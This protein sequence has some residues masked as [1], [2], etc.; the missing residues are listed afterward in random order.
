MPKRQ[1]VENDIPTIL[2][3][4]QTPEIL[5]LIYSFVISQI[6][7][8]QFQQLCKSCKLLSNHLHSLLFLNIKTLENLQ[9]CTRMVPTLRMARL[10]STRW[11]ISLVNIREIGFLDENPGFSKIIFRWN[12]NSWECPLLEKLNILNSSITESAL[13]T[14]S[15]KFPKLKYLYV[16]ITRSKKSDFTI[17]DFP[18]LKEFC[19]N[20]DMHDENET[21]NTSLRLH[22]INLKSL[23]KLD[24]SGYIEFLD[25]RLVPNMHTIRSENE[26]N[27]HHIIFHD[28]VPMLENLTLGDGELL[29]VDPLSNISWSKIK[30]LTLSYS[31]S[32]LELCSQLKA[33]KKLVL[34]ETRDTIPDLNW[35]SLKNLSELDWAWPNFDLLASLDCIKMNLTSFALHWDAEC[36]FILDFKKL[37]EFTN[38]VEIFLTC[39]NGK[40]CNFQ[41]LF[42]LPK[43][44]NL[45]CLMSNLTPKERIVLKKWEAQK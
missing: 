30:E 31:K 28:N 39:D 32:C 33:I 7:F 27:L 22:I 45:S 11:P 29:T 43:I 36:N 37:A 4:W 14:M 19:L 24:L 20:V 9:S 1:R 3:L 40:Y 8:S 18:L 2:Q 44:K 13:Q 25:F 15:S 23:E 35:L 41:E 10:C 5:K 34:I 21:K 16:T 42:S 26:V 6:A 38:L 17:S 12:V